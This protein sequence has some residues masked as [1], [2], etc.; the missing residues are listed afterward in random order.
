MSLGSEIANEIAPMIAEEIASTSH[1]ELASM[2][3]QEIDKEGIR[4]EC[5]KCIDEFLDY[6]ENYEN[7]HD[8]KGNHSLSSTIKKLETKK[9]AIYA[10][11]FHIQNL[12]NEYTGQIIVMTYVHIDDSGKREIR[13]SENN[14]D[15]LRVTASAKWPG[16][17]KFAK[18]S[19]VVDDDYKLLKQNIPKGSESNEQP[20]QEAA[21]EINRRYMT[22]KKRVL[23][24]YPDAWKGYKLT[25]LGPINEAFV[26]CY[27]HNVQLLNSL[28]GNID[29]FMEGD[30]G[31]IQADAT[32]GFM[33][34]DVAKGGV[35]YAVKGIFGSPQGYK[36]LVKSFKELKEKGFSKV[37]FEEVIKQYTQD[38]L[39]R[40]YKPQIKKLSTESL[41]RRPGDSL[42][43]IE[44]LTKKSVAA[45]KVIS[46]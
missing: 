23:W 15:H 24:F 34:G 12:M 46:D 32:R 44:N 38:E 43:A 37:A 11:F 42:D 2:I 40:K 8:A 36:E 7:S 16:G 19:Y 6:V 33:I 22:Y 28:E 45:L 4:E 20:L 9:E 31:A 14:I 25:S 30:Y 35:Q 39:Q 26:N 41:V 10:K 27:V 3:N 5:C 1:E 21:M 17:P 18:L 29:T 13:I